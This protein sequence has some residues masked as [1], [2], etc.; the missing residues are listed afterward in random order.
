MAAELS[1][2]VVPAVL[3]TFSATDVAEEE[4]ES[5]RTFCAHKVT[6]LHSS[7]P[8]WQSHHHPQHAAAEAEP[9]EE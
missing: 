9:M 4:E 5:T 1:A 7:D 3:E 8:Q 2:E 6:M